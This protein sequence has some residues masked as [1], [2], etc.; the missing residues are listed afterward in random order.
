MKDCNNSFYPEVQIEHSQQSVR[1]TCTTKNK[2]STVSPATS[3]PE[4]TTTT[5]TVTTSVPH[6]ETTHT[7]H[8]CETTSIVSN[9]SSTNLLAT[10]INPL[11]TTSSTPT[12]TLANMYTSSTVRVPSRTQ[13]MLLVHVSPITKDISTLY[14]QPH[15]PLSVGV[16]VAVISALVLVRAD[17]LQHYMVCT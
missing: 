5:T 17:Q 2:C 3:T 6:C 7:T 1:F 8:S 12:T 14:I 13:Q 4:T 10:N 15:S 9:S 16:C 11:Y